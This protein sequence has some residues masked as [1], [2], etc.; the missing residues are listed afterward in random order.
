MAVSFKSVFEI[1]NLQRLK[2]EKQENRE[3]RY[4]LAILH[5]ALPSGIDNNLYERLLY[6][7]RD[8][9]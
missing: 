9:Y 7:I 1:C 3:L 2:G 5:K 6:N 4:G 8:C